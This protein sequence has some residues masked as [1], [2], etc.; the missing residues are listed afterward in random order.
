MTYKAGDLLYGEDQGDSFMADDPNSAR[1]PHSCGEWEIGG[2]DEVRA[3]ISDLQSLARKMSPE[4]FAGRNPHSPLVTVSTFDHPLWSSV[5]TDE[6]I[7]E[8]ESTRDLCVS[9]LDAAQLI[10]RISGGCVPDLRSQNAR[11]G[12]RVRH[13]SLRQADR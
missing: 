10:N 12:H 7:S 9:C 6:F 2:P 8:L 11:T 13:G 4:P 1:L 3:L 5:A